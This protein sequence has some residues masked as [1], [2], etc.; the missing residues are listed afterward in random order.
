MAQQFGP[1]QFIAKWSRAELSERAASQEHF[2]DL[3]RMLGQPT[4]AE[5][6]ATGAEY[7]FEKGVP[8]TAGASR[9]A[10]GERGFADVWWRGKFAWEY[11]RKDKYKDLAEAYRQ[12]CQYR[13]AL[14]NPPLLIVSDIARTEIH[15]NFTGTAKR[16]HTVALVELAEPHALDLL[17]RV[18]TDPASF[19]PDV[20]AEGVTREV[21]E[22]I[23]QLAQALRSRGHD[24][25]DSAHF[26]MKCMFCLF[27][28]DVGLLPGNL[29]TKVL[30]GYRK[31]PAK[32]TDRLTELFD[33]MRTGGDFGAD[34]VA[35]FNGGLFDEAP[36]LRLTAA[37]IDV[38]LTAARRD[39][40]A[41][42]PAIFGTLFERSLDPDTRAQIGAHYTSR[43]DIMLV[44]EP[45]VMVPLRGEWEAVKADVEAQLAKR[46]SATDKKGK[47]KAD[48]A[49]EDK[50]HAFVERLASIRIL[51]PACGSGN[52]LYV[53]IQQLLHLEKEVITY[54]ARSDIAV[55]LIPQVRPTQLHGIELN[56]YAAELA[57]V[58]IWIGYLQWM[59]D[60]GF[61]APRDPILEPLQ[62][63]E[64]R[65]AI[66]EFL[67]ESAPE[68]PLPEPPHLCGAV[69]EP[70]HSCGED[71]AR[72]ER[73]GSDR[74]RRGSEGRGGHYLL[75]WTTYGTWLPGDERGFVGRVPDE[76]SG[77]VIHNLPGEP[78]DADEPRLQ[79]EALR[80]RKGAPVKL[81]REQAGV[82]V[83][84]FGEVCVKYGV[85]I[86]AGAVMA[87]HVH[88]VVTSDESEGPRLLNLFKGVSSRRLGQRFGKQAS[89]S[90]WTTG[91]SR[92][93]LRDERAFE[94]AV[95]Y[96]RN[97]G[98]MLAACETPPPD[99]NV[100]AQGMNVGA[101]EVNVGARAI[102]SDAIP[103]TGILPT[104]GIHGSPSPGV[105]VT[106][107]PG[108]HAS[109][110]PGVHAGRSQ[111]IPRKP[112]AV[113]ARWPDADFIIGNPPFLGGSLIWEALGTEYR[114]KLWA[115]YDIPGFSDLCC[116]W[117][118][119]ARRAIKRNPHMRVG[120]LATQ[121]IRGGVNR[122]VLER[123]KETGDIFVAWSDRNWVLDGATVHV[124][125]VGF[126]S[127]R[128]TAHVLNGV[129]VN[130]IHSNLATG[131]DTTEATNLAENRELSFGGTKKSGAFDVDFKLA[132]TMLAE[133]TNAN[134]RHNEDVLHPWLNG[135]AITGRNPGTWIIDFG[136]DASLEDASGYQRPF[137]HVK[138]LVQPQR[139]KNKR[140]HRRENW[141]LH[142]ETCPGMRAAVSGLDRFVATPRVS[143]FR[144]YAWYST[145]VLPDDGIYIFARSDDYFFGVIHSSIHELWARRMGTQLREVESGFRY[146]P[147]TCFETF[148][149]PWAPGL[150]PPAMNGGAQGDSSVSIPS[151]GVH[152]FPSPGVHASLSPGVH[153]G[154]KSTKPP[155]MNGGDQIRGVQIYE[156]ISTAARLLNEQRERWLN[157]P[158]WVEPIARAVDAEDA[159]A[160]VPKEARELIR[161]SAIMA[162]AAKD[163]KL[164]KRTL[165][166]LY[167]ERPTWLRLLH[168]QLDRAVLAA[169]AAT[170]PD[171]EWSEDWAP[172]WVDTGAGQPLPDDHALAE[173]RK[174]TDQRVLASLLRLN[175]QR[176][177]G[178]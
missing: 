148:P 120:L 40:G 93:L 13:E 70:P 138:T 169:Y 3:C 18:F 75:T 88:L 104:P 36:A 20:T 147:T 15:T 5:H 55:G 106:P 58:V 23:G 57:Q 127:G 79:R 97:Q 76:R 165:T 11:K 105:H 85:S 167:N 4:P 54:A 163:P 91:G 63:I 156:R 98:H 61:A 82:C 12:L 130:E 56:P 48:K 22:R 157:P 142:A 140:E 145:R 59:R 135:S 47:A 131:A 146:T 175:L 134:Q 21:A 43:D 46:R 152:A 103:N 53:A 7:T 176:A 77:H 137:E 125:I 65:D 161:H 72:R 62:T 34:S 122:T 173:L 114:D 89:G 41:V 39:W 52:F 153:A 25:H 99:M 96:V 136:V 102:A 111:S 33:K 38:L 74:D 168:E 170:D 68:P 159:F 71:S 100:G 110:S 141:W 50:L 126:D 66:L 133:P 28:E 1:A 60:N 172:V 149:F 64:C 26:L 132:G 128:D 119:L 81:T 115:S 16:V 42:E 162:R 108:V 24:P 14:E 160:D 9:G 101:R 84:A 118:E 150:E 117:F 113:P 17:R 10:A 174:E 37:D 80:Q 8:P 158:E 45:V 44:V 29:F 129:L 171:G 51:D 143:K 124:S 139:N 31:E 67:P 87:N 155:A 2:I 30:D 121:G 69:S 6:D 116:Y 177:D 164:K 123:I 178:R 78:Y 92:R 35:Y 86:D 27:A 90:W 112:L 154:R 83:E 95:N 49:I 109:P 144:L 107:T 32:L 19:K 94:N 166:N 73:R 151:P